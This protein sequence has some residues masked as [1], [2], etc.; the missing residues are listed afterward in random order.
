[1]PT[2]RLDNISKLYHLGEFEHWAVQAVD[3]T[4]EQGDFVFLVGSRGA[5]KST[6]INI[7]AGVTKPTL[8][9]VFLDNVNVEELRPK[10]REQAFSSIRCIEQGAELDRSDTIYGN[11]SEEV[12]RFFFFRRRVVNKT[13]ADKALAV[14]GVPE[15]GDTFPRDLSRPECRRVLI[16]KAVL[17]SP[18]ILMLDDFTDRMDED[19][20]WD[21]LHL[22]NE[23]NRKGTTI[24]MS[25]NSSYVVNTM[26]RRVVTL[27]DGKL[28][29]DVKRGRYGY[30]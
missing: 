6:L 15:S 24:I 5:G 2:I 25:T 12:R 7:M 20:V 4:I 13:L 14:V 21:M 30:I 29:G 28:V 11:L 10:E 22:L 9:K 18:A 19:T 26:R 1:M 17:H 23:L 3:L 8:G 16:A 27:A